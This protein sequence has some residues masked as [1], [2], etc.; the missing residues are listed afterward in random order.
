MT[1]SKGKIKLS[2]W[3]IIASALG[4]ICGLLFGKSMGNIKFLGDI[5][6]RLMQMSVVFLVMGAITEAIGSLDMHDIGK[7]GGK[8]IALFVASTL[9]ASFVGVILSLI[10]KPG[11]GVTGVEGAAFTGT[12]P[13][14]NPL[15]LL[16]NFFPKNIV[17]SM[18]TG[19][20]LQII[21]FSIFLG[22]AL[23][24][25]KGNSSAQAVFGFIKDFNV[26]IM[27]IVKIVMNFAP[28]GIFALVAA[29]TGT[30]GV[31][32]L[33]AL[34]KFLIALTVGCI[35][36]LLLM[37]GIVS[38]YGRLNPYRLLKKL[39]NT[40]IVAITTT[41]SAVSLPVQME[42]S[43]LRIGVSRRVSRLVNPLGM[44]LNSHGLAITVA[45]ACITVA[46]FFGIEMNFTNYIMI[47]VMSTLATFANLAVP[48]GALVTMAIGF[49][50]TGLPLEGVAI[51]AGV[52]WFAGIIRTLLNVVDDVLIAVI[53]AISENELD[54][55]IFNSDESPKAETAA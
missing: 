43:E 35:A 54:R 29:L 27:Q 20:I 40:I 12:L 50:M 10:I 39:N 3:M 47:G 4:I 37:V 19:S 7:L 24:M 30:S 18:S 28:I 45:V 14:G 55:D 5:F 46:Q 15:N 32:M 33:M 9:F 21:V 16:V 42:D 49:S 34:G 11:V 25:L 38:A 2:T 41:S 17:E 8:T 22:L 52:D 6:L 53:V 48:G 36:V 26:I 13:E 1:K 51:M 31:N 44:N 23:S